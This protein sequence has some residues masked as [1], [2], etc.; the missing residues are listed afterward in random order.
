MKTL[1]CNSTSFVTLTINPYGKAFSVTAT[2]VPLLVS[3]V[4]SPPF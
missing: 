4:N 3:G 1:I 2:P